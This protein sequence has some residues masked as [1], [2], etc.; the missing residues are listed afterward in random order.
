MPKNNI[1][2]FLVRGL[3]IS[4]KGLNTFWEQNYA[5]NRNV[6]AQERHLLFE[7][8]A[9]QTDRLYGPT[10]GVG[11]VFWYQPHTAHMLGLP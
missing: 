1:S 11:K 8:T 2:R 9:L 6:E 7:Y 3:W 10:P 5:F 4:L